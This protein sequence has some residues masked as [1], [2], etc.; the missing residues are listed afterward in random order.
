[1]YC[2]LLTYP[3]NFNNDF[4]NEEKYDNIKEY[5]EY[6]WFINRDVKKIEDL[7]EK[8]NVK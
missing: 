1:M 7:L 2:K 5:V 4:I 3:I 6:Y 8:W